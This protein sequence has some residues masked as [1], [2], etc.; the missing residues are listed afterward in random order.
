MYIKQNTTDKIKSAGDIAKIA[1]TLLDDRSEEEKHKEYFYLFGMDSLNSVIVIDLIA[2]GTINYCNPP[3]REILRT[4]I[5]KNC[6][7]IIVCHNHPSGN[8]QA[9]SNDKQFTSELSKASK[10]IGIKLLDHII[11]GI[12]LDFLSFADS[13]LMVI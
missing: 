10:L 4:A 12:D 1:K 5:I 7:S 13:G 11:M 2:I 8:I 6:T 9:S 3:M